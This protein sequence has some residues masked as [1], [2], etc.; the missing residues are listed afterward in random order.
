VT[1]L[2]RS[3]FRHGQV[4]VINGLRHT[5]LRL[6]DENTWQLE[7][8]TTRQIKVEKQS[9]LLQM[10]CQGKLVFAEDWRDPRMVE[11]RKKIVWT[12]SEKGL[13]ERAKRK[14]SYIKAVE[15]LPKNLKA[16]AGAVD[17]TARRLKDEKPP[18]PI[19]VLD[20]QRRYERYGREPMSLIDR[21]DQKGRRL[22][23]LHP[24]TYSALQTAIQKVYLTR[25]RNSFTY[26]LGYAEGLVEEHNKKAVENGESPEDLTPAPT[27]YQLRQLTGQ[28]D[29]HHKNVARLGRDEAER[30]HR[31]TEKHYV[32]RG[33]LRLAEIDHA[34]IDLM[35]IDERS[36]L[37]LGRPWVTACV[38]VFSRAVL[39]L[40][41]SFDDPSY[42]S[43]AQCLKHAL[44]PKLDLKFDEFEILNP[45]FAYG[46]MAELS[47]DNG[48]DFHSHDF[49]NLCFVNSI[50]VVYAAR[51]SGWHKPHIERFLGTLNHGLIH[52]IPGTTFANVVAKNDYNPGKHA[53]VTLSRLKAILTKWVC[54]DY[55]TTVHSSTGLTPK[56]AWERHV[57]PQ[58]IPLLAA[59]LDMTPFIGYREPSRVV[60]E[61]GIQLNTLQYNSPSLKRLRD[62]Y[63]D[64]IK[65][66]VRW[67]SADMGKISI[68]HPQEPEPIEIPA[69]DLDY[70]DGLSLYQHNTI[71]AYVRNVKRRENSTSTRL[72][73]KL[74]IA[75][76]V[77][78]ATAGR[79]S[80]ARDSSLAKKANFARYM[81][82][83]DGERIEHGE[84]DTPALQP[85]P[86]NKPALDAPKSDVSE[87]TTGKD[88]PPKSPRIPKKFSPI[89]DGKLSKE[90][91]DETVP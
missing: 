82:G 32:V 15:G 72:Q 75:R 64:E 4:V 83:G 81:Q 54:D 21:H 20:W 56:S 46:V 42:R 77:E 28:I 1:L 66:E 59:P 53:V 26:T 86:G 41:V 55:H 13:S 68:V 48:P 87:D 10:Y 70:A 84:V 74:E 78:E 14:L 45:W 61:N 89:Y 35:V 17:Q 58:D 27:L 34:R 43:V 52:T 29:S 16:I 65:V 49:D 38:D 44:L 60:S 73:A 33:P 8:E 37:P 9:D 40:Y 19:T 57:T 12:M 11:A 69:L 79:R 67:D 36:A 62:R 88:E 91:N 85:S 90:N 7:V 80:R 18:H 47:T 39:G 5:L 3:Q 31:S 51:K 24:V 22:S 6:F 2:T 23:I 71:Q 50:D 76:I 25:N 30:L 63:G